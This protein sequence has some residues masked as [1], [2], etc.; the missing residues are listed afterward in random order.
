MLSSTQSLTDLRDA[1]TGIDGLIAF[2][3]LNR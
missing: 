3:H 1:L 2:Y